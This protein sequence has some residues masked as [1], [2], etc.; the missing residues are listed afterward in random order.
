[1]T[2][3]DKILS[4]AKEALEVLK[5]IDICHKEFYEDEDMYGDWTYEEYCQYDGKLSEI[6]SEQIEIIEQALKE[7]KKNEH[8]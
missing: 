1:M 3:R 8:I 2:D 6:Y 4:K 7:L 5:N